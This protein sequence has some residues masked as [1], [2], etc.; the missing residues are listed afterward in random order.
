[1]SGG[2]ISNDQNADVVRQHL[3]GIK[4]AYYYNPGNV[5]AAVHPANGTVSPRP[6]KG[7]QP[8]CIVAGNG[9]R[10][11]AEAVALLLGVP[12]HQ[13]IVAQRASG[14]VNVRICESVLGADVYIIQST[15]GNALVDVNTALMELLLLVRKMR[16]SNARRVTAI[17]T[18]LAYSKRDQK[19]RIRSTISSSAVAQMLTTVGVDRITTL[20]LHTGQI[21][22]FFGNTPLDNLEVHQEFAKY[23]HSQSWFDRN[24]MTIVALSAGSIERA[25][26]LADT[27]NV[28]RIATVLLRRATT[29]ALS[30]QCVGEVKGCI[31]VIVEDICDTVEVLVKGSELLKQLGAAKVAACCTHG[32]LSPSCYQLLN[33]CD[34]LSE[35]VVTDSIPQEEHQKLVPKLRVLTVAPLIATVILKH[36]QD[37]SFAPLLEQKEFEGTK[38]SAVSA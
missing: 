25:R 29:S 12:T 28:D 21:Q 13:T 34:A 4:N 14:E 11:L 33:E 16:L 37:E 15:S 5:M 27:L 26:L 6:F 31:C 3:T 2:A 23:L 18:F 9:N 8:I 20:D 32:I 38:C 36:T 10:P 19:R 22:G 1:M 7:N 35:L 17:I 30:L 24:N